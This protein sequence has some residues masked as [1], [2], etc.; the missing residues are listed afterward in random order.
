MP[1]G[2]GFNIFDRNLKTVLCIYIYT[3]SFVYI[4]I[5]FY[6]SMF[7]QYFLIIYFKTVWEKYINSL[8]TNALIIILP[9][10]L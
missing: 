8:I 7:I 10:Q 6:V 3:H 1:E 2:V 9:I 4:Y 5:V